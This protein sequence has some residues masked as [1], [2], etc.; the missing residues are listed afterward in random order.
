MTEMFLKR[1]HSDTPPHV[2]ARRTRARHPAL[3]LF[4][5]TTRTPPVDLTLLSNSINDLT[6]PSHYHLLSIDDSQ[7]EVKSHSR[8][9]DVVE[10][11]EKT[12]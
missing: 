11:S 5:T 12:W 8:N 7:P 4:D 10:D 9:K 1:I 6:T 3:E 2:T